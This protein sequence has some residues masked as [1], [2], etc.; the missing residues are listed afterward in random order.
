MR[1]FV[2]PLIGE[3]ASIEL[4]RDP[5]STGLACINL[6]QIQARRQPRM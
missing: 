3:D 5:L 1:D 6:F 4:S 2:M